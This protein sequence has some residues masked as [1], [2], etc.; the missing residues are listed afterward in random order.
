MLKSAS[1]KQMFGD[2][3]RR[4]RYFY[5]LLMI[6]LMIGAAE[7]LMEREIIFPEMAALTIGMWIVDKRVWQVSRASMVALM[8]LG[9]V[10]GVCIV[11]YSPFPLLVN[12]AFAFIFTAVCLTLFRAT[13][14]PQ[15]SACMLPVLLGTESWVYPVAVLVMSVIVVV[16]QWGMEKVGLRERVTYTP[17]IAYWKDSLVRWSF[18]LVTVIAVAALA[19]Y[20]RNLYL[21][22]LLVLFT[23]AVIGVFFQIVGHKFLYLPEGVVVLP[24]FLCM[25][26]LFEFLGK[27]FAPAGAVALIPMIIPEEG[28]FW[29]PLQVLV[30][31]T[32]FIGLVMICF[33]RCI[34]WPRAQLIVCLVPPF[35]R[36]LRKRNKSL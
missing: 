18:L 9:A 31:A 24:I 30:G 14:V 25:F 21:Q 1:G 35:I 22:V 4:K 34:R 6:L 28:L 33:Q 23:A 29:L 8:I 26:S 7:L 15:I 32:L 11:R 10:T 13:L 17:V 36:D 16:G 3:V 27:F 19:I 20:T 2:I 5:A 12:L